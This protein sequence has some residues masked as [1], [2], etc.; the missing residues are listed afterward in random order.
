VIQAI[1]SIMIL[2]ARKIRTITNYLNFKLIIALAYQ[3]V[4]LLNYNHNIITIT[5]FTLN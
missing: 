2:N 1:I 3:F 4:K 5:V